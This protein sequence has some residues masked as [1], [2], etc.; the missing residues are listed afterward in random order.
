MCV[1]CGQDKGIRGIREEEKEPGKVEGGRQGRARRQQSAQEEAR[2]DATKEEELEICKTRQIWTT[3]S[4][5]EKTGKAGRGRGENAK[6]EGRKITPHTQKRWKKRYKMRVAKWM[7]PRDRNA[8]S[9]EP[10]SQ[11]ESPLPRGQARWLKVI[12]CINRFEETTACKVKAIPPPKRRHN[13]R[14][15]IRIAILQLVE[16]TRVN[17]YHGVRE[18]HGNRRS[19]FIDII[20]K[21]MPV[22]GAMYKMYH[23]SYNL[24]IEAVFLS[25]SFLFQLYSSL[26]SCG[27]DSPATSFAHSISSDRFINHTSI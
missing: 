7:F 19:W 21:E 8:N 16:D 17:F 12:S 18:E 23:D 24:P 15:I 26:S 4:R 10:H 5:K 20:S 22:S 1:F 27:D 11:E 13:V 3:R 6:V 25:N 2:D 9:L 14:S